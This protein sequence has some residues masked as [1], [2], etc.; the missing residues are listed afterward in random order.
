MHQ[1]EKKMH[2]RKQGQNISINNR[3]TMNEEHFLNTYSTTKMWKKKKENT[4]G[5]WRS[6]AEQI[7]GL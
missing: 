3:W 5:L 1:D 2:K 7:N 6:V 4:P